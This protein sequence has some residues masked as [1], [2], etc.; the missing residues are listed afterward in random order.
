MN[1]LVPLLMAFTALFALCRGT[2]LYDALT[3]G[4]REGL[5]TVYRIFPAI[6]AILTA[7]AMFRASGALEVLTGLLAPLLGKVGIPPET[8][9]LMLLRPLSG[10]AALAAGTEIIHSAGPDSMT[11]RIAAVMLGATETTFYT[12]S[13][14][15]GSA[16]VRRSRYAIPAAL[17]A[18]VTG[19][20]TA[21]L[22]VRLLFS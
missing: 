13:V 2:P 5:H 1:A 15:L 9:G 22:F 21:A 7:S 18:D 10:S 6:A 4:I 16:G 8:V 11:G 19:F 12:L 17:T 3:E 14:Y 20:L